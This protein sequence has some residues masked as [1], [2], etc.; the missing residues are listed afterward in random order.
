MKN[1]KQKILDAAL[2]LFN[3]DGYVNVRLQHIADKAGMSIGNQGY[4]F[5]HK[6]EMLLAIY[7]QLSAEQRRLLTDTSLSPIFANFD[8][9]ISSLFELQQKFA[10]FYLD[11]LEVIR[12]NE[13]LKSQQQEQI[14]W[15]QTQLT[16][17]L[18][19]HE[20]RGV[21]NW[22]DSNISMEETAQHLWRMMDF[23]LIMQKIEGQETSDFDAYR[24]SVWGVLKPFFT[25][26]GTIEFDQLNAL[27][28]PI[29]LG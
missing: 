15:Q 26:Q 20:A 12:A 11:M 7:Q 5:K 23:W 16:L 21:V 25:A 29:K 2:S 18:Q 27:Q 13:S 19:M 6:E 28:E 3:R 14:Q 9:F 22:Q 4:H 17:L 1:T 24:R 10:F 8:F